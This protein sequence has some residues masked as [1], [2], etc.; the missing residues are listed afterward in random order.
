MFPHYSHRQRQ[1]YERPPETARIDLSYSAFV[2]SFRRLFP[3]GLSVV[4]LPIGEPLSDDACNGAAG[5]LYVVY[6]QPDAIGIAEIELREITVQVLFLAMLIDALHAA[7]ED[8]IVA[9]NRIGMDRF[10]VQ[11]VGFV[12]PSFVANVLIFAVRDRAVTGKFIA[13]AVV[14][15]GL[16]GHHGRFA[17]NVVAKDRRD[18]ADRRAVDME[19]TGG[20][21]AL[22]KGKDGVLM[23]PARTALFGASETAARRLLAAFAVNGADESFVGFNDATIPS[24]RGHADDAHGFA[25]AMRHE[26]RGFE[27]DAQGPGKLVAADALLAGAKQVHRLEP[28][29]HRDVAILE[30]G[31]DLHGELLAALVA[32]VEANTG[33][34]S[35]HLPDAVEAPAMGANRAVGPYAG[36]NPGDS[37]GL[38]LE[39]FGG[40]N[41]IGHDTRFPYV[42]QGYRGHVGLSSIMSPTPEKNILRTENRSCTVLSWHCRGRGRFVA[43][44][45]IPGHK[46]HGS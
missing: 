27:G 13:N 10:D 34:L 44:P 23:R 42:N 25:D 4:S 46:E 1:A 35:G 30:H 32:L 20:T 21:A 18:V 6:A 36:L 11:P 15:L 24:H 14:V 2:F 19:A 17:R 40:Q 3:Y 31:P 5:S 29:V 26:P 33:R 12:D 28:Q 22:D 7:L 8:R 45:P 9:F 39:D 38:V 37:G 43:G 41:R 16:I